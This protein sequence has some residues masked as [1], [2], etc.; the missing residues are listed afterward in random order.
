MR[1]DSFSGVRIYLEWV[2]V[3]SKS[4]QVSNLLTASECGSFG[5]YKRVAGGLWFENI[6]RVS[7]N[8]CE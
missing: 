2:C 6:P 4:I 3:R 7:L 8:I 5:T 1:V